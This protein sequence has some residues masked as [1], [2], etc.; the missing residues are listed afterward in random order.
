VGKG[1]GFSDNE[2]PETTEQGL[3]VLDGPAKSAYRRRL[4][5]LR[6][7]L[8]EAE[9]FNDSGRAARARAE[10]D[11]ITKQ[12]VAAVGLGGRDR[13]AAS[14]AER[15]RS[16]VR[17]AIRTALK[18]IKNELPVLGDHLAARIKTGAYCAYRPDAA[19]P[20]DW[21]F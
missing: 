18:S 1:Q 2:R 11:C 8:E 12:L 4:A 10:I 5:D 19:R 20:V 21:V 14:A 17:Q 9:Q 16:T 6:D 3:P 7:E 13:L 15:A